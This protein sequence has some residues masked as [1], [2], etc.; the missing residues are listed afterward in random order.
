MLPFCCLLFL[1]LSFVA[2]VLD[3]GL[4]TLRLWGQPFCHFVSCV[5]ASLDELLSAIQYFIEAKKKSEFDQH[6]FWLF[7]PSCG[8]IPNGSISKVCRGVSP[9]KWTGC[10]ILFL[11]LTSC[12]ARFPAWST[13]HVFSSRPE[14]ILGYLAEPKGF[15]T[16][17][18]AAWCPV[19]SVVSLASLGCDHRHAILTFCPT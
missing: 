3:F 7:P 1:H 12:L 9:W 17:P 11:C 2:C 18:A 6:V 13:R 14:P 10:S 5:S 19:E 16:A 4:W 15:G 8:V